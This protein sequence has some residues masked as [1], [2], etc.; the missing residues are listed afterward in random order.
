V[1]REPST[2][3]ETTEPDAIRAAAADIFV[4]CFPL[5][6]A[7][8]IRRAHPLSFHQ[9]LLVRQD[10]ESLAP[11]LAEDDVRVV[12]TSAWIDLSQQPVVVRLPHTE[13][14][15]LNL[16]LFD[17][18]GEPFA[19]VGSR[20]GDDAGVDLA[21]VGPNWRGELPSGLH[22]KRA[23]SEL[24]WGVSRIHAHSILDR[25]AT[26]ALAKRQC[27]A[28]LPPAIDQP[29]TNASTL[30]S[31]STPS[32]RQVAEVAPATLFHRL[33]GI[34]DRAPVHDHGALRAR[35]SALRAKFDGPPPPSAWT[36]EFHHALAHGFADGMDAIQTAAQTSSESERMG[37]P[38]VPSEAHNSPVN[39]LAR[40][41]RAYT[42]AGAPLREDLLILVCERD[43]SGHRLSGSHRYRIHFS[44][45]AVPP[46]RA[47]WWL[48]A[49]PPA[50]HEQQHGL[51]SYSDL[52]LNPDGSFDIILQRDPPSA[53]LIPNWL[54]NPEG[55]FSLIMR[56][57][58]PRPAALQGGWRMPP[59]ERI[60]TGSTG[61]HGRRV[62]RWRTP[63]QPPFTAR[64]PDEL[65][66]STL[67]WR[68]MP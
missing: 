53:D 56:L 19:S 24:I 16:T 50:G 4:E 67:A 47:F 22:A 13:G 52:E 2:H 27:L 15:Y 11:G 5:L 38:T 63:P 36:S 46:V 51:G 35:I 14:R 59:V 7:D 54:A 42:S 6:L 34:L 57:Y 65:E 60:D 17:T 9:F 21:L 62:R 39:A 49:R 33:D 66:A 29:R 40:A 28:T 44:K 41:A 31:P 12:V 30:D 25:P 61:G 58:T 43:E 23:P 1:V 55:H 45:D 26:V 68:T 37:W 64:P 48:S 32:L 18:A 8:A 20:T 3:I 10:G